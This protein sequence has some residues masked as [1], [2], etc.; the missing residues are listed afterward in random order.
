MKRIWQTPP[1]RITRCS[2]LS[3]LEQKGVPLESL[4]SSTQSWPRSCL[5]DPNCP[6]E[7]AGGPLSATWPLLWGLKAE[8]QEEA[9]VCPLH[10]GPR[11]SCCL[12]ASP[13]LPSPD[14]QST[15]QVQHNP[16]ALVLSSECRAWEEDPPQSP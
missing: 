13:G 9:S 5:W 15:S 2:L 16:G 12:K 8:G 4:P 10:P 6:G 3:V 1:S 14:F 11:V 7:R